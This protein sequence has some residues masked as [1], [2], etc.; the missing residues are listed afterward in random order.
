MEVATGS[1]PEVVV[2]TSYSQ[3][4]TT[5]GGKSTV[6]WAVVGGS[7]PPGL[8]LSS[9]G[10]ISGIP[11]AVGSR[12]LTVRATDASAPAQAAERTLVLTVTPMQVRTAT[13]KNATKS[14][15]Y[16]A[17]LAA[18]GGVGP[19]TWS[20]LDGVL[21][22]GLKLSTAGRISGTPTTRG[23]WS[24][25]VRVADSASPQNDATRTL[26]LTVG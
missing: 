21:P 15:A 13:L 3:K 10:T 16:S 20:V 2:G 25:T 23:T 7:L 4:L 1:L 12:T 6:T 19:L 26:S 5:L 22:P 17:T 18:T 9:T 24:F 14:W 8:S 11:T